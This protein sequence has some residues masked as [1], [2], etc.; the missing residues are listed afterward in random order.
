M[1]QI[2]WRER[3]EKKVGAP[4]ENQYAISKRKKSFT[5]CLWH[6]CTF[7][8]NDLIKVEIDLAFVN[9]IMF[10]LFRWRTTKANIWKATIKLGGRHADVLKIL[11]QKGNFKQHISLHWYIA[12]YDHYGCSIARVLATDMGGL[13]LNPG[14]VW[15]RNK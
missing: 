10:F 5:T 8:I 6:G 4:F 3:V 13:G 7:S 1:E 12:P 11:R 2:N 14:W 9:W 15:P